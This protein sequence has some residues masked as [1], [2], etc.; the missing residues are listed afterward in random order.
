MMPHQNNKRGKSKKNKKIKNI[1]DIMSQEHDS[2]PK[3]FKP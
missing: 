3:S 2:Y 1:K